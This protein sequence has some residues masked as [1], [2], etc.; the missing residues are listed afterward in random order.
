MCNCM[1]MSMKDINHFK[2]SMKGSEMIQCALTASL[3]QKRLTPHN[4][5]SN[6]SKLAFRQT[7]LR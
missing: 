5:G 3:K 2:K 7:Y 4:W 1:C 6:T